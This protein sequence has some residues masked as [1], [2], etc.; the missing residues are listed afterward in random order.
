MLLTG[1]MIK[2]MVSHFCEKMFDFQFLN[3][4]VSDIFSHKISII[5]YYST[6]YST[7]DKPM[8]L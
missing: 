5:D 6:H 1:R 7:H 8:K 3:Y 2:W 4:Q